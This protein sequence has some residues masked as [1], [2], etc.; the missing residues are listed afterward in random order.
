MYVEPSHEI[1]MSIEM[2]ESELK[3]EVTGDSR[4]DWI[5]NYKLVEY[6]TPNNRDSLYVFEK[7]KPII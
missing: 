7:I 1:Q 4:F 3:T 5:H 2:I 6:L